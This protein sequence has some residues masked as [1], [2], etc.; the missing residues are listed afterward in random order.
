MEEY[1]G[2]QYT[3]GKS[4]IHSKID[5]ILQSD[6]KGYICVAD[7]VTLSM[8]HKNKQL[9]KVLEESS[10]NV[11]DSAW[12]PLYLRSL[13]GI[14]REQYCGSDFLIDIV[15]TKK[16]QLLFLGGSQATLDAL[17]NNLSKRNEQVL[18]MSFSSLPFLDVKEF[19]YL[20]IAE[21]IKENNPDIIF[22]SLGMPKQ[23]FFMQALLP[24]L[25]RG[26]LIGVGAAFKFHSGLLDQK[27]A[28]Q[29]M[30]K[31]KMEWVYRIMQEP[32]KQIQRCSLILFSMPL[33]YIKEYKNRK[34]NL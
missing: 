13:Y 7:G 5:E 14:E 3:F 1:F 23:E 34:N 27:R 10:I 18:S 8:S 24:H 22:I 29:W 11:C 4:N 19:N 12:V 20:E 17:Q 15:D 26:I 31:A 30:I 33:I 9:K 6:Q 2:I 28:P 25:A 16:Y 32:K 21:K